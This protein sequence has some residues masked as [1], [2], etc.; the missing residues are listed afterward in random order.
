MMR[1]FAEHLI[2]RRFYWLL[3]IIGLTI[4]FG[5]HAAQLKMKTIFDDLF[6]Q[7][8]RYI[9]IHKTFE[10]LFGGANLVSLELRVKKGTIFNVETLKKIKRIGMKLT[11]TRKIF[12]IFFER[13]C[14]DV[15]GV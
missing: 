15:D 2:R 10:E 6:P 12:L 1:R 11:S 8:H 3:L 14:A 7:T 5:Y 13:T 9:I 4:F